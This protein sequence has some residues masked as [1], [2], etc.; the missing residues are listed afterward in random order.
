MQNE[1]DAVSPAILLLPLARTA[2]ISS[3]HRLCHGARIS[4]R[5]P[6]GFCTNF[7]RIFPTYYLYSGICT[8]NG[9]HFF[10]TTA[11]TSLQNAFFMHSI[12]RGRSPASSASPSTLRGDAN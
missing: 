5:I 9:A 2:R 10:E 8:K 4:T 12:G 11:K 7:A 1:G 6:H 3:P